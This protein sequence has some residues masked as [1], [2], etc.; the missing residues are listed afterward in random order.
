MYLCGRATHA[1]AD[2]QL[3]SYRRAVRL[4]VLFATAGIFLWASAWPL[5]W[6]DLVHILVHPS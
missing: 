4:D 3:A 2:S 6:V 1:A 5:G